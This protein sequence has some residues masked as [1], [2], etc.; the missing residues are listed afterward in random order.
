MI[1]VIIV[2]DENIHAFLSEKYPEWDTQVAVR[3][4]NELW[5]GLENGRLSTE[6]KIVIISDH[7]RDPNNASDDME[8]AVATL[9]PSALVMVITWEDGLEELIETRVREVA[10]RQG[11]PQSPIYFV[12][13]QTP[14]SDI[15]T[16]IQQYETA[17]AQPQALSPNVAIEPEAPSANTPSRRRVVDDGVRHGMILSVT[18]SKGGAGKSSTALLLASQI[19]RSSQKSVEL[20]KTQ[21]PLDVCVVDMDVRDGQIGFLIGQL[22]PT[23]LNIRVLS[24]WTPATIRPN[25]I[26][27]EY[28]GIHVLLAPKRPRS[29]EDTPPEFYREVITQLRTM[30]DIVI[31][32]TSVNYLDPLLEHV[33]Y[34]I[35][36]AILF[37]TDL[38]ISSVF[39]MAR[40]FQEVVTPRDADG[41]GGM[42]IDQSKIGVVVNK[43]MAGVMMDRDR[44]A[45][46]AMGAPILGAV[47]SRPEQFA[48]AGNNNRLDLL[49]DDSDIGNAFFRLSKRLIGNKYELTPLV[50]ASGI[51]TAPTPVKP[52]V[53]PVRKAPVATRG[54]K[55]SA[56]AYPGYRGSGQ[57][58]PKKKRGLFGR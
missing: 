44:V 47:P 7:L 41:L 12:S 46:A 17:Q 37:V 30:F 9:A 55:P 40:W 11:L 25:L 52:V 6:S 24:E 15:D 13:S 38:G 33:C 32:D 57:E 27:D 3:D 58:A 26:F 14:E 34:P 39:G 19:A 50:E 43:S 49:L 31:L 29:S 10:A 2:A 28:L 5:Q 8:L 18:S 4:I 20:G 35:A 42:G 54:G 48:Q 53:S 23:A 36:D 16:A 1:K 56:G 21:R 51:E 22:T 45:S